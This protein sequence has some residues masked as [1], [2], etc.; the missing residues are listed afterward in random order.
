MLEPAQIL[1][2]AQAEHVRMVDFR[3][4]LHQNPELSFQEFET[5]AFIQARLGEL[6]VPFQIMAQT[7]VVARIGAGERCVAL[8]A[9]IDALPIQEESGVAFHSKKPGLMHACGHD[10]HTAMLLGAAAMLKAREAEITALN[11]TIKLI[12]QPG[13]EMSPGGASLLIKEGVLTNPRP[14]VIFGQHVNPDASVGTTAFVGGTMMAATDELYWTIH[15]KSGHAAQPHNASDPVLMAA[16][17]IT[18]LQTVISRRLNPFQSGVLSICTVHGGKANNVIPDVVELSGTLR[19][20]NQEW[21]EYA[22][23][24]IAE[25][26]RTLCASPLYGNGESYCE[27]KPVRGYPPLVNNPASTAFA[28]V[29]AEQLLGKTQVE[30][31]EPKMWGEDF[32]YYTHEIPGTFWMLGIRPHGT[33]AIPGLH[34]SKFIVDENA[35]PVG[36]AMLVNAA[37]SWL[38]RA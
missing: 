31:F 29:S 5:S 10:A 28:R 26:S 7:G 19:S 3:R 22:L 36:A 8:R 20:M 34:N 21:R 2:S 24:A 37:L 9:D 18:Q 25:H 6:N 13:E 14:E 12:F 27:F 38:K 11:G 30:D 35:L 1:V 4:A 17:L 23:Q 15:G 33:D 32:A 16:H